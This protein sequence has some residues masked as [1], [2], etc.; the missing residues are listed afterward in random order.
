MTGCKQDAMRLDLDLGEDV[1]RDDLKSCLDSGWSADEIAEELDLD[2]AADVRRW[3]LYHDLPAPR[4]VAG[5]A[6]TTDTTQ[7]IKTSPKEAAAGGK[8]EVRGA[9]RGVVTKTSA[10][11]ATTRYRSTRAVRARASAQA[12]LTSAQVKLAYIEAGT[13]AL[14]AK[15]LG[16]TLYR[17]KLLLAGHVGKREV[18]RDRLAHRR[19]LV[20][21][22]IHALK[23][24]GASLTEVCDLICVAEVTARAIYNGGEE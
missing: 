16:I 8:S 13:L 18:R 3:C 10:P 17:V 9:V 7:P 24:A 6:D 11:K 20:A 19:D 15:N 22:A 4:V 23:Q 14:A 21:V 1:S 5:A 2:G 12:K